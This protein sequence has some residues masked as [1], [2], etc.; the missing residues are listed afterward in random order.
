M[1]NPIEDGERRFY[2]VVP[3][4]LVDDVLATVSYYRDV[5]G[6]EIDFVYGEP[7]TYGSVSRDDAVLNFRKSD[8]PGRR[9][10]VIR[11]GPG[12]GIDAYVVVSGVDSLCD[13]YRANGALVITSPLPQD[14]GM[15]EFKLEDTNGYIL[16]FA[17]EM[18]EVE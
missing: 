3:V 13:E 12:N 11:A 5:L 7:P 4:F 6:F 17:E 10:G 18:A 14:Y 8:P 2:G 15:K 1:N 9:N 16:V